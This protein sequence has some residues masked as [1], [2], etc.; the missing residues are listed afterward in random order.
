LLASVVRDVRH[1]LRFLRRGPG[2]TLTA[3]GAL[4]MGIGVNTAIV[5]V[6]RSDVSPGTGL[7][8]DDDPAL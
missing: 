8:G 2:C 1:A 4:A 7:D 5:S 3:I 6:T